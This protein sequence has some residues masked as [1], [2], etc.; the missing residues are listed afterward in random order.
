MKAL[1]YYDR[2]TVKMEEIPV[3]VIGRDEVLVE[4]KACGICSSDVLD[5]YKEPKAPLF[6]G[7]EAVGIVK[8]TGEEVSNFSAGTRVFVHHHI[9]CMVC[10]YCA[11]GNYSMCEAFKKNYIDPGGFSEYI[12]VLGESVRKGLVELPDSFSFIEGTFIE[13]LACCLQAVKRASLHV[14][15]SVAIFGAGFN[16]LLL[17]ILSKI[18][19]AAN[20]IVVEPNSYRAELASRLGAQATLSPFC[21]ALK[22]EIR[23]LNNGNLVDVVFVTPPVPSVISSALEVVDRGGTVLLYAPS[24]PG[25]KLSLEV[26]QVYFSQLTIRTSY[27][28]SPLE[29]RQAVEIL[30]NQR[31]IFS[32]IPVTV[33][34]F[35][36]FKEAFTALRKNSEIVKVVLDFEKE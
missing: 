7:H 8:Q 17:A 14:G 27:S 25:T 24:Q 11:K 22:K 36:R 20:V 32:K 21:E 9:P 28:A 4:T 15:D 23:D 19:G 18:F 33:Y 13:P 5:W 34:P 12:R 31:E 2:N 30:T 35:T 3:P 10:R 16:G 1:C 29:T 6:F 26:F